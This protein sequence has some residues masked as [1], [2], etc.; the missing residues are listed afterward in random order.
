MEWILWTL[1]LLACLAVLYGLFWVLAIANFVR[2]CGTR[3]LIHFMRIL[4]GT[5]E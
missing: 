5:D 4:A 3:P 1:G 2:E